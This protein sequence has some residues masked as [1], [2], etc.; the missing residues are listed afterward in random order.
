M[1]GAVSVCER[2][3]VGGEGGAIR[4]LVCACARVVVL[5]TARAELLCRAQVPCMVDEQLWICVCA[6]VRVRLLAG[7]GGAKRRRDSDASVSMFSGAPMALPF[8]RSSATPCV[9]TTFFAFLRTRGECTNAFTGAVCAR[10]VLVCVAAALACCVDAEASASEDSG[11]DPDAVAPASSS[12][13]EPGRTTAMVHEGS[14]PHCD[15]NATHPKHLPHH[16]AA[17]ADTPLATCSMPGC[18]KRFMKGVSMSFHMNREHKGA[19]GGECVC[20]SA[21]V[22]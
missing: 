18:G 9:F 6:H 14:C 7:R 3:A 20:V 13:T 4:P 15:H 1:L 17:H 22:C 21:R 12:L 16:I 8:C 19:E 10:V 11:S 5:L 2:E